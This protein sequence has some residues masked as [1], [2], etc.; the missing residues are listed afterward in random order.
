MRKLTAV[1]VI[2]M[3]LCFSL[4][5]GTV[6]YVYGNNISSVDM[7]GASRGQVYRDEGGNVLIVRKVSADVVMFDKLMSRA[8][9]LRGSGLV[10][11]GPVFTITAGGGMNHALARFSMTTAIY[12]FSPLAMAGV[13]YGKAG[14][15]MVLALAGVDVTVPL[16]RLWDSGNTFIENG[17]FVG[18]GT[19]G[20]AIGKEVKF[21][22]CYGLCYRHN[23]G[24]LCWE[25]GFSW[26]SIL[27][28]STIWTPYA[29]VGVSF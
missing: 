24:F 22:S 23:L 28:M 13:T 14:G 16:A 10:R 11:R 1:L 29:G 17:K 7:D 15:N 2:A 20:A 12:P 27:G 3:V 4:H 6:G 21:A 25:A 18:Y 8:A 19:A 26:L 9:Y 5:A